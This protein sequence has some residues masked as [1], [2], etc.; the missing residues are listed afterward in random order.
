M[1]LP[2]ISKDANLAQVRDAIKEAAH[3]ILE[4]RSMPESE[5][6]ENFNLELR[7][8]SEFVIQMDKVER[9]FAAEEERNRL[10]ES[11]GSANLP[12]SQEAR[13]LADAILNNS[14]YKS[15][16]GRDTFRSSAISMEFDT[17]L[18]RATIS[19]GGS[20]L[21]AAF[22]PLAQPLM[23][24]VQQRRLFLTE[25]TPSINT[26]VQS[27][28]YIC[29]VN[30]V[31]YEGAA[32]AVEEAGLKPEAAMYWKTE[33]ATVEKVA[34]FVPAT[35]EILEDAPL[36]AGFINQRLLYI[37]ELRKE[38]EMLFGSGTTPHIKGI[39]QFTGVQTQAEVTDDYSAT[40]GMAFGKIANVDGEGTAVVA[41]AL[42]LWLARTTRH[43]TQ[44]DNSGN[45][46]AP[47]V[48]TNISWG[49]TEIG[50]R[51]MPSGSAIV[52][53]FGMGATII[54]RSQ[55]KIIVGTQHSDWF[56]YNKVAI[57][58]ETRFGLA[59]HRPDFFVNVTIPNAV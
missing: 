45:G 49:K 19:E 18:M 52:G 39:T 46:F 35:T 23:P 28:P 54:N 36:L 40:V 38:Y 9:V 13:T 22:I 50:T 51:A 29:E 44:L 32:S 47:S 34:A 30:S 27:V 5:R 58:C 26:N 20:N 14:E 16:I 15:A 37:V 59:V 4:L 11:R 53:D 10:S 43:A 2:K 48:E 33:A 21:G 41:N 1:A 8:N 24:R 12:K 7:D 57:L 55:A 42:D 3:N 6:P 31:A 25:I 17:A 56:I